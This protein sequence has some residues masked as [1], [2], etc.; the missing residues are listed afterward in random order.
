MFAPEMDDSEELEIY[1]TPPTSPTISR[2]NSYAMDLDTT[3]MNSLPTESVIRPSLS[4]RGSRPSMVPTLTSL[5]TN[6]TWDCDIAVVKRSP[7]DAD[8]SGTKKVTREGHDN[9][10]AT[11]PT[12]AEATVIT[13]QLDGSPTPV[14]ISSSPSSFDSIPYPM[15]PS[16]LPT[17]SPCFVHSHLDKGA[18]LQ[19]WLHARESEV[20]IGSDVGVARSLQQSQR[21]RHQGDQAASTPVG[22]PCRDHASRILS[23]TEDD[24]DP[25]GRSLTKQLA[26]TAV[27]VREMSKQLGTS[28]CNS[29]P[30]F[31]LIQYRPCS[32]TSK[33]T[34]CPY[35]H[36]SPRQQAYQVNPRA[37]ALPHA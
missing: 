27:G 20:S 13:H 31:P 36:Q 7:A 29:V 2:T 23:G 26:E 4:R 10:I 9:T 15:D 21:F 34:K 18:S 6:I 14:S 3:A 12:I 25:H 19:D 32:D 1:S 22:L 17:K 8:A 37:C 30:C 5:K 35:R 16:F 28:F 24:D 33:H 11:S